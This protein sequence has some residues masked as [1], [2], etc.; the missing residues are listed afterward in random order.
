MIYQQATVGVEQLGERLFITD[1][2]TGTQ[3]AEH[4]ICHEKGRIIKNNNHYPDHEKRICDLESQVKEQTGEPLGIN[5]CSLL[6]ATSLQIYKDQLAGLMKVPSRQ[7]DIDLKIMERLFQR[8][9]LTAT[10]I[11]DYLEA[12]SLLTVRCLL[13]NQ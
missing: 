11:R 10:M 6:K 3:I 12:Y 8:S 5:I 2:E 4:A 7:D 9:R 1:L 13:N